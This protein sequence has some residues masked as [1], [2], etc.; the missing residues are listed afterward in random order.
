MLGALGAL[1]HGL[2]AGV[3]AFVDV[4]P[5]GWR[6]L[7]AL[8][9]V[10]LLLL[11]WFRRGL[12][13]TRRFE[14]HRRARADRGGLR[15]ALAPVAAL[16]R[17][18]PGRLSVLGL[19]IVPWEFV[20]MTALQFMAKSLQEL[21]GYSPAAVT[22]L[23]LTGGALG[24][25]GNLV[26]GTLSDRL[27]RRRVMGLAIALQGAA[28]YGFYNGPSAWVPPLWIALVFSM[29]GVQV[30]F[31]ALGTELFPTSYRS[32]ASGVRA[33]AGTLGGVAGLALEGRLYA[34]LGSHAA[35][36]TATL[37]ILLVPLLVIALALPE[38]AARELE[39]IAPER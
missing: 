18:Y 30:L 26:A 3:F 29:M 2:S 32:T 16:L 15:G 13:E 24:I 22:A 39:E 28:L 21:H 25:L 37:P 34:L 8:G 6:A 23:Y 19:A 20:T 38:T 1:G 31:K 11:A 33:I 5:H 10:P 12:P 7:Y 35:A 9:A 17:A 14:E 36:I 27:G 4:L